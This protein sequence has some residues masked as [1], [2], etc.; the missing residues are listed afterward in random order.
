MQSWS[1]GSATRHTLVCHRG[2]AL[3]GFGTIRECIEQYKFGPI[4]CD[5]EATAA[6]LMCSLVKSVSAQTITLDVPEPHEKAMG[7]AASIGLQPVFETARMYRGA[8]PN[9]DLSR[10]FGVTTLELG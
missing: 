2:N 9:M 8:P 3:T 10:L 7:L 1:T 4:I 5:N 6:Q